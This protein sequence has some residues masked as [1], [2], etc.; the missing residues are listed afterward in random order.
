MDII[1]LEKSDNVAEVEPPTPK[2]LPSLSD[3]A[4]LIKNQFK[5]ETVKCVLPSQ[6]VDGGIVEFQSDAGPVATCRLRF[7]NQVA[8][9]KEGELTVQLFVSDL[10]T[11]RIVTEL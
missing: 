2:G 8:V 6:I 5:L 1:E 10:V 9:S 7:S 4:A 11:R 3:F